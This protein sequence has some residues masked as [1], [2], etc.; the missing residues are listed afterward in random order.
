MAPAYEHHDHNDDINFLNTLLIMN[1]SGHWVS[2]DDEETSKTIADFT[3]GGGEF[4]GAGATG[5]YESSSSY[6]SGSSDSSYDSGS[7]DLGSSSDY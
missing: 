4:G 7:S 5:S 2:Y 1:M 6:D 3:G